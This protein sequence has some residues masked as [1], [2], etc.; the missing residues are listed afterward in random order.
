MNPTVLI[1]VILMVALHAF[2]EFVL[3]IALPTIAK[4]IDGEQWYGVILAS[5][6]LS[7]IV[8]TIWAGKRIDDR[9]PLQ[10]FH[11]AVGC[12]SIG[13]LITLVA[14]NTF[15]FILARIFQGFGGGI[16]WTLS[17]A[18][19]NF[20]CPPEKQAK[21]I[22]AIDI[23]FVLPSIIAPSLGG[24]LIDYLHWHW[25]F[26]VQFIPLTLSLLLISPRIK[27]L[28]K[29]ACKIRWKSIV[30]GIGIAAGVAFFLFII[31][32][33][34]SAIW[35]LLFPALILSIKAYNL[36]MPAQWWQAKTPL[37][38][39]IAITIPTFMVLYSV[40]TFLPL[41]LIEV[42]KL[43]SINAGFILFTASIGWMSGSIVQTRL[44][45]VIDDPKA[46]LI[47][48]ML[49]T[50]TIVI[51]V[52]IVQS[53]MLSYVWIYPVW[54]LTGLG[55]GIAFNAVRTS[56]LRHTPKDKEGA[57]ATSISLAANMGLGLSAGLAGAIKNQ[58]V[59]S[60]GDLSHAML[61]ICS[62]SI[63]SGL[64]VITLLLRR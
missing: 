40:E 60:G 48:F 62:F 45:Q 47:G 39:A 57:T 9:G 37:A 49:M 54:C 24:W 20:L 16:A 29:P 30:D 35:L 15:T 23:A 25:I 18:L 22:A 21:A 28:N 34:I 10:V 31:S 52:I 41:Y 4:S 3:I 6:V 55:T 64:A 58:I 51:L 42:E 56:A 38:L 2:D 26:I 36:Y 46:M 63:M 53:S 33:P 19:I 59:F 5:Y 11:I 12:F 13:L 8:A 1:G 50:T 14:D 32:T 17:F 27:H 7:S 44:H 61:G 43:S